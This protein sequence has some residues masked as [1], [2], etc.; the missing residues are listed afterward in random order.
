MVL[1]YD[2]VVIVNF[3]CY[4][5]NDLFAPEGSFFCF[6]LDFFNHWSRTE[7]H[8][9]IRNGLLQWFGN[10]CIVLELIRISM[11]APL[12]D[13]HWGN[14]AQTLFSFLVS[15]SKRIRRGEFSL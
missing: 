6:L 1:D 9:V 13:E 4:I 5:A 11:K 8:L 10:L 2:I 14:S 12:R 15:E 3:F 7:N